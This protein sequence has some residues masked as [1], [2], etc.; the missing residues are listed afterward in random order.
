MVDP[1]LSRVY[2][3][4]DDGKPRLVGDPDG[5]PVPLRRQEIQG[6]DPRENYVGRLDHRGEP[7]E[8]SEPPPQ[9]KDGV[10]W[11]LAAVVVLI[12]ASIVVAVALL[13]DIFR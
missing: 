3:P 5:P 4:A 7:A 12:L 9:S 13:Q 10:T 2:G 11:L 8:P 6:G 1:W